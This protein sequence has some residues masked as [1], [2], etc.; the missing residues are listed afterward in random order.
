MNTDALERQLGDLTWCIATG[1]YAGYNLAQVIGTLAEQAPEPAAQVCKH[2]KADL[3]NGMG[4]EGGITHLKAVFTSAALNRLLDAILLQ[5]QTGGNL[6]D[7][8]APIG[9]DLTRQHGSDP[10]FHAVMRQEAQE[11]GAALPDWVR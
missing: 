6:G 4:L 9:E 5:Q 2:L 3:V 10:A 8:I 11:L 1:L 7:I